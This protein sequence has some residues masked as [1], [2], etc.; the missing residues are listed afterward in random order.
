MPEDLE[1]PCPYSSRVS[2]MA[3][4]VSEFESEYGHSNPEEDEEEEVALVCALEDM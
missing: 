1:A 4:T 2:L 3:A